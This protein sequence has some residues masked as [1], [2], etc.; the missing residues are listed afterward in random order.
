MEEHSYQFIG[1]PT[2]PHAFEHY[3]F[4]TIQWKSDFI[5]HETDTMTNSVT[6]FTSRSL[7][8]LELDEL[9]NL[10]DN[11]QDPLFFLIFERGETT[12]MITEFT[13]DAQLTVNNKKVLQTFIFSCTNIAPDVVLDSFKIIVEY[14]CPDTNGFDLLS[15]THIDLEIYDITRDVQIFTSSIPLAEIETRWKNLAMTP[16][17]DTVFRTA[18]IND[19]QYNLPTHDC[20][21]QLRASVSHPSNFRIRLNSLQQLF[22]KVE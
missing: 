22:Y 14:N 7:T 8:P 19:L 11:Y 2:K 15:S 3:L 17:S 4:Q 1:L 18:F 20:M 6:V 13:S 5:R 9:T 16:T 10:I 21:W 12:P